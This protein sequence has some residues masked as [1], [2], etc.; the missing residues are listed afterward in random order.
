MASI[1]R[2]ING[3]AMSYSDPNST[4]TYRKRYSELYLRY[5]IRRNLSHTYA[6][7]TT[8]IRARAATDTSTNP[9]PRDSDHSPTRA[10]PFRHQHEHTHRARVTTTHDHPHWHSNH[11]SGRNHHTLADKPTAPTPTKPI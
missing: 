6:V 7:T 1:P 5:I 9:A 3:R 8:N 4:D 11:P 2:Q 10:R